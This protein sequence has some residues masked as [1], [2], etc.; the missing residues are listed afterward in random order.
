MAPGVLLAAVTLAC[1][2]PS[3]DETW[4]PT[5][6][7]PESFP[8]VGEVLGVHCGTLDCHGSLE[9]NLRIYGIY[10][11]RLAQDGV[12]GFGSTT[13]A[14]Y[15]ATYDAIVAIQPE[16]LSAIVKDGGRNPERW[17][18]I[19]KGR[20]AEVHVGEDRLPMGSDGDR[21]LT[22]WLAGPAD[23]TACLNAASI[24]PPGGEAW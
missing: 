22:S 10:G 11:L 21:C 19:T 9:R 4:S 2:G 14:A 7:P 23:E 5:V 12:T 3:S 15:R 8:P 13:E 20:G 16:V 6:P 1:S 17:I 18:V 24:V